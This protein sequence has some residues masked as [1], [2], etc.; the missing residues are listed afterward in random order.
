M[1]CPAVAIAVAIGIGVAVA[2]ALA[3]AVTIASVVNVLLCPLILPL[4]WLLL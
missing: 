2:S 1:S 3:T 4:L